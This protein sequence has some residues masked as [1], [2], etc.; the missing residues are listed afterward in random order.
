MV[1]LNLNLN[2]NLAILRMRIAAHWP[3]DAIFLSSS[4][5][6]PVAASIISKSTPLFINSFAVSFA[7]SFFPSS[8]NFEPRV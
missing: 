1:F 3:F 5:D 4:L 8:F 6:N 2:L 7:F